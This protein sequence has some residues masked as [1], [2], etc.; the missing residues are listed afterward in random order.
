[1][2]R[3]AVAFAIAILSASP[4][5]SGDRTQTSRESENFI[6]FS[7]GIPALAIKS[8]PGNTA[9]PFEIKKPTASKRSKPVFAAY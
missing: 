5:T 7:G 9:C 1:M 8:N 4:A 3:I 6:L 2:K